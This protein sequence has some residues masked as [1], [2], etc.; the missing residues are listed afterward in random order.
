M[1]TS[2]EA[3]LSVALLARLRADANLQAVLAKRV[4]DE[5]PPDPVYPYLHLGRLQ[6]RPWGGASGPDEAEGVEHVVTLTAVSRFG[7]AQEA[8]ATAAA[9]RAA[10]HNAA[11]DLGVDQRLVSLRCT[12]ADVFRAAD[13][14]STYGV[15]RLRAVTEPTAATVQGA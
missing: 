3:A 6:S 11:I 10:L 4:Y 13:W 15:V 7:G 12:Y 5:P 9:V 2:P 14:R 1:P 8:K